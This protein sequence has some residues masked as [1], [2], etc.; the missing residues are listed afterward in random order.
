MQN[1]Y[2]GQAYWDHWISKEIVNDRQW[3][4]QNEKISNVRTNLDD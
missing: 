1:N 4:K 3:R 2:D